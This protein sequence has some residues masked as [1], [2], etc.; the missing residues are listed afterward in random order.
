LCLCIEKKKKQVLELSD[1]EIVEP[2][3]DATR[4]Y[5]IKLYKISWYMCG[6]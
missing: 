6:I 1:E 5:Y 2:D 4:M 3:S